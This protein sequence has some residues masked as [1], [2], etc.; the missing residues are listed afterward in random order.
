MN[1]T[2]PRD[3][4]LNDPAI[5]LFAQNIQTVAELIAR[6]ESRIS[7]GQRFI[8]GTTRFFGQPVILYVNIFFVV[9]WILANSRLLGNPP[10]DTPP[11]PWLGTVLELQAMV[12]TAMVLITQNRQELESERRMQL[13][14]QINLLSEQ[15]ISKI[16][17]L[18]DEL[19][20]QN[21]TSH[22]IEPEVKAMQESADPEVLLTALEFSMD[23]AVTTDSDAESL[24]LSKEKAAEVN[25]VEDALRVAHE[26][27]LAA[28]ENGEKGQEPEPTPR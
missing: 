10:W 4:K 23:Q 3:E 27:V 6:R 15:K 24:T 12:L 14:L 19:A 17:S 8:E 25:G 16:L 21:N 5:G 2:H 9:A 18:L 13:D 1:E 7:R 11:F 22:A 28:R 26:Q 20:C